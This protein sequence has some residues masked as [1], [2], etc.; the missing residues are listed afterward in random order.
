MMQHKK[1]AIFILC[2]FL[3][4][5]V[6][7]CSKDKGNYN[8]QVIN[9]LTVADQN[10]Q[11]IH[12]ATYDISQRR[13]FTLTPQVKGTVYPVDQQQ[14]DF[15]WILNGDTVSRQQAWVI[16]P[17]AIEAGIYPCKLVIVDRTTTLSNTSAFSLQV[18]AGISKGSVLL[19]EDQNKQSSLVMK[20]LDP[21]S[22]YLSFQKFDQVLLGSRPVGINVYF[23][24]KDEANVYQRMLITTT[25]GDFP[26][27]ALDFMTLKP[28]L[29]FA[30]ATL[31]KSG[32]RLRPTY[33]W[34]DKETDRIND[35]FDGLILANGKC[36]NVQQ[37]LISDDVY[38]IDP[39][40]YDFGNNG[41]VT[42]AR[43]NAFV[44]AGFDQRNERIRV[45]HNNGRGGF[46]TGNYDAQISPDLT[47]GHVFV[48]GRSFWD[49][50]SFGENINW[51]F[52]TR[53]SAQ[54]QLIT[55]RSTSYAA[56]NAQL[57]ASRSVPEMVDGVGFQYDN[58]YWYF[59]RGRTV[60][61]F[62][63]DLTIV[64]YLILPDDGSGDI[65][66]WNFY[67]DTSTQ[68]RKIGV[69]TYDTNA[70][71]T[72]KGSYYLYDIPNKRF[73]LRDLHVI[74]K[75]VDIELCF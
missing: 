37:G 10:G 55:I 11:P 59:A 15:F 56:N 14:L 23:S 58:G 19:T 38:R 21:G 26:M 53:K 65:T 46:F 44:L 1:I 20:D 57:T 75:A 66:A 47:K 43:F 27:F 13:A 41:L 64:P 2:L 35:T 16:G 22:T 30:A 3:G 73:E 61:R 74:D 54:V 6:M 9:K 68:N 50:G 25:E 49:Y 36:Y 4:W 12:D 71:E 29:L 24:V 39:L 63:A 42:D 33:Y 51:Q 34:Q 72:R 7:S 40:N 17:A 45:F 32:E 69:A 70:A 52:L 62:N 60:Y 28:T 48:A 31:T 8:Y 67:K 5:M 18:S